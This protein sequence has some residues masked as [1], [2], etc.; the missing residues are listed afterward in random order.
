[1][2]TIGG[3]KWNMPEF[4]ADA[5]LHRRTT[6]YTGCSTLHRNS[7]DARSGIVFPAIPFA[8]TVMRFLKTALGME[9]VLGPCAEPAR[10]ATALVE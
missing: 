6:S 7:G 9:D 3:V 2:K 5:T 4:T 1:M 8:R 10:S